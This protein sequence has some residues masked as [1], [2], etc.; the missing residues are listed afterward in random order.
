[1]DIK[2]LIEI[3]EPRVSDKNISKDFTSDDDK[4]IQQSLQKRELGSGNYSSVAPDRG[5]SHMVKKTSYGYL[6][7]DREDPYWL[8]VNHII[9]NK[10]WENPYFPRIYKQRN[11]KDSSGHVVKRAQMEKL[12]PVS[13]LSDEELKALFHKVLGISDY[14][15]WAKRTDNID[16]NVKD[17]VINTI[18]DI[19]EDV[20]KTGSY[21]TFATFAIDESDIDD[22]FK[23]ALNILYNLS[24]TDNIFMGLDLYED[25]VM[26][27]RGKY[28]S[29]L[30]FTDIFA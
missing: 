27:R 24:K 20:I 4:K 1:M 6:D 10:L 28:G 3:I 2:K 23:R 14:D 19:T 22:N 25:N 9:K 16:K 13:V 7:S 15:K 30:V 18:L 5:D 12:E 17:V 21:K 29:Q 11:V 26:V 8:Y